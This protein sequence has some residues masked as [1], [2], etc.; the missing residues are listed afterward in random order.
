MGWVNGPVIIEQR[1]D[2]HSALATIEVLDGAPP[3]YTGTLVH[4][5]RYSLKTQTV[6]LQGVDLTDVADGEQVKLE[7]IVKIIGTKTLNTAAGGTRTVYVAEP[8]SPAT[9]EKNHQKTRGAPSGSSKSQQ[10]EVIRTF[11]WQGSHSSKKPR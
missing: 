9:H 2:T 11:G 10:V 8:L 5:V 3:E 6:L 7:S 4:D 1:I